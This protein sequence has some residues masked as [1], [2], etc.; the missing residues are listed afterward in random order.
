MTDAQAGKRAA[1]EWAAEE[2]ARSAFGATVCRSCKRPASAH[3]LKVDR[4]TWKPGTCPWLWS[5][6]VINALRNA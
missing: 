2:W 5:G 6:V 4:L 1:E 3:P